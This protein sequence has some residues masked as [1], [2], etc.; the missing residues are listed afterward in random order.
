MGKANTNEIPNLDTSWEGY[1]GSSVE[2]F[3]K[4]EITF[5][6]NELEK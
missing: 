2:T 3:I 1:A 6:K 5:I 4:N